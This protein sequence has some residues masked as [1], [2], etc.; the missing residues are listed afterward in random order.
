MRL[1]AAEWSLT[2]KKIRSSFSLGALGL[3]FSV[4]DRVSGPTLSEQDRADTVYPYRLELACSVALSGRYRLTVKQ[5]LIPDWAEWAESLTGRVWR[6]ERTRRGPK[7]VTDLTEY[8]RLMWEEL[9]AQGAPTL[10]F[11]TAD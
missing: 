1:E 11:G 2:R 8:E 3:L 4:S 7:L 10:N 9:S 6:A 5:D